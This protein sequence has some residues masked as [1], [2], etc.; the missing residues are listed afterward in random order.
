MYYAFVFLGS[1]IIRRLYKLTISYQAPVIAAESQS[2]RFSVK[3]FSGPA[4]AV[5]PKKISTLG[6]EPPLGGLGQLFPRA[7]M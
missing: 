3:S 6:P 5:G 7:G 2:F 4:L 1:I